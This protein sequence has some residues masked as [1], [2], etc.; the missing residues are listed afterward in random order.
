MRTAPPESRHPRRRR[1]LSRRLPQ[2]QPRDRGRPGPHRR[3]SLVR[4]QGRRA[5]GQPRGSGRS[6]HPINTRRAQPPP[7]HPPPGASASW[8]TT[9]APRTSPSSSRPS[10]TACASRASCE[11]PHRHRR[12][13]RPALCGLTPELPPQ[14][15]GAASKC[16]CTCG[17][18]AC[19]PLFT[20]LPGTYKF[21]RARAREPPPAALSALAHLFFPLP[22]KDVALQQPQPL[23]P[24][25]PCA[26][27]QPDSSWTCYVAPDNSQAAPG[28]KS[29]CGGAG[30]YSYTSTLGF[31]S[32]HAR[33]GVCRPRCGANCSI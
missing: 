31:K 23:W 22:V 9:P 19:G 26:S 13:R 6:T 12:G 33:P 28:R 20:P 10:G 16:L 15:R 30:A 1:P 25:L 14:P 18:P 17:G 32:Q 21:T 24:L 3:K 5:P 2:I 7:P 11:Y 4:T 29:A 27:M 8:A